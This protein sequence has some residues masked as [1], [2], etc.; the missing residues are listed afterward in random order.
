MPVAMLRHMQSFY[1]LLESKS[2]TT[3]EG[4]TLYEGHITHDFAELD[5]PQPYYSKMTQLMQEMGCMTQLQRGGRNVVSRWALHFR[6]DEELYASIDPAAS[7]MDTLREQ[8]RVYTSS[9]DQKIR[10]V[11]KEVSNLR[12]QVGHLQS[13]VMAQSSLIAKLC[14]NAGVSVEVPQVPPMVT[15]SITTEGASE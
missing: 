11:N 13:A 10:T 7:S 3:D 9:Q 6:P 4:G 5:L 14:E 2:T 12:S 1:D 15:V 8:F